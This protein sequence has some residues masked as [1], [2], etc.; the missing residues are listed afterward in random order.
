[1]DKFLHLGMDLDEIIRLTTS[2]P[3]KFLGRQHELGT[4]A[5]GATADITVLEIEELECALTDSHGVTRAGT[6]RFEVR[7]VFRAGRQA[8]ILPRPDEQQLHA[9]SAS[10]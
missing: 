10:T 7:H 6:Q 2:E 9:R 3:A 8:G 5:V 1:M 4:L